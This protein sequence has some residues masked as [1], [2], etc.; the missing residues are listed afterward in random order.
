MNENT[1]KTRQSDLSKI[2][3][4]ILSVLSRYP[5]LDIVG[6]KVYYRVEQSQKHHHIRI[7]L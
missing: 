4:E 1:K 6:C 5:H 7:N 2:T 3:T